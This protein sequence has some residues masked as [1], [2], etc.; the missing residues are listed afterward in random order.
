MASLSGMTQAKDVD[1]YVS[2]RS[3]YGAELRRLREENRL[4]QEQ[5]GERVFCSGAYIGQ[6][7][8]AKR[9]PQQDM[10]R[11]LDGVLGSGSTCSGCAGWRRSRSTPSTSPTPRS[12]RRRP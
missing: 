6:F 1:P 12:W 5:L 8:A 2:P 11:L 9:R 10:S 4:S 7:E 3:F